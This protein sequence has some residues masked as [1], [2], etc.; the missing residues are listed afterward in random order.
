V[1]PGE[2]ILVIGGTRF[3]GPFVLEELLRRGC[4]AA[5]FHRGEPAPALDR[6]PMTHF[7]GNLE[8][9]E[10]LARA[11]RS[12]RPTRLID[13]LHSHPAGAEA[14]VAAFGGRLEHSVHVS[15]TDVYRSGELNPLDE[16]AAAVS[17]EDP[18]PPPPHL[19]DQLAAD[20]FILAAAA[21]G[22]IPASL[23]R[24]APLYGP[25]D[26]LAREWFFVKRALD[27]REC[28]ALP[29]GG[30][31]LF[32][33]GFVQNLAWAIAQTAAAKW[34]KPEVINLAD[35]RALTVRQLALQVAASLDHHWELYSVPGD[36]WWTPF[37]AVRC[38]D[39][40]RAKSRLRYRDRMKPKDA[41]E[42]TVAWLVQHPP[43]DWPLGRD[44]VPFDYAKED[45][46]IQRRGIPLES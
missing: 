6:L 27:R 46:L 39:L 25:R 37:S 43:A 17:P 24:L 35:E 22:Q 19:L 33:R 42:L 16:A 2:R 26:Y 29:E 10:A 32:H 21:R 1:K 5:V 14:V 28:I 23:L 13:L 4:E 40:R 36:L 11:G 20:E 8:D 44:R 34:K 45:D 31:H 18:E 9:P 41:L 30:V 38:F 12:F 15:C 3:L 7:R